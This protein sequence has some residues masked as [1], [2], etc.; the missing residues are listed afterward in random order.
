[1]ALGR[2]SL[3]EVTAY[4]GGQQSAIVAVNGP[5]QPNM[6]LMKSEEVRAG[7]NPIP[8]PGRWEGYRVVEYQLFQHNIYTPRTPSRVEDCA[9]WMQMG[10]Q[11]FKRL[12]RF[13]YELYPAESAACQLFETY[14]H[15][16]FTAMLGITPFPKH[17]LEGRLQRQLILHEMKVELHNPMRLFEEITRHRLLNGIL[18]LDNL[19][20]AEELD[21]LVG[22]YTAWFAANHAEQVTVLGDHSEGQIFLPA[23]GL[24]EYYAPAASY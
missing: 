18:E 9:G 10:F 1:M 8:S 17:S 14:P 24:K 5:R 16:A 12:R 20:S 7:L 11:I 4:A 2:G 13:G 6:G 21:A 3:D 19:L 15:A 23:P 22:A